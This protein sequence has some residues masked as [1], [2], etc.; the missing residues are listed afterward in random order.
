MGD[1]T[2][3][4]MIWVSFGHKLRFVDEMDFEGV[5]ARFGFTLSGEVLS[6]KEYEEMF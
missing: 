2:V 1:D 5:F 3:P 6:E 4:I